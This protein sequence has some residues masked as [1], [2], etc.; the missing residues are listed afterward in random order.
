[1]RDIAFAL[2]GVILV[3]S[4]W[5]L[6]PILFSMKLDGTTSMSWATVWIPLWIA[7]GIGEFVKERRGRHDGAMAVNGASSAPWGRSS[8]VIH[9][10]FIATAIFLQFLL[11]VDSHFA[12]CLHRGF[13]QSQK[14]PSDFP[15]LTIVFVVFVV[16]L[17]LAH[18]DM[19]TTQ[20][21]GIGFVSS[22]LT[23][24][25]RLGRSRL[26][27]L[28]PLFCFTSDTFNSSYTKNVFHGAFRFCEV[29]QSLLV[30]VH[31]RLTFFRLV[32]TA[33]RAAAAKSSPIFRAGLL[34]FSGK[35]G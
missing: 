16:V 24:L 25:E 6:W 13:H 19:S 3:A 26:D 27:L 14:P 4:A 22:F 34:C 28:P 2:L 7:S 18:R 17:V 30:F 20:T 33:T 21:H 11:A 29:R 12:Q 1:M 5:L 23:C 9:A 31:R 32:V 10:C 8:S 35:L 15:C